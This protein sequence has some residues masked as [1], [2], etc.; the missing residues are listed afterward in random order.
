M[1]VAHRALRKVVVDD[2][3]DALEVDAARHDVRADQ[4]PHFALCKLADDIVAFG[5]APIGVNRVGVDPVEHELV[6]EFLGALDGL[7]KDE[8]GRRE[9]A[10]SDQGSEREEFV[11]FAV[12]K[13]ERLVDRRRCG[14]PISAQRDSVSH[15]RTRYP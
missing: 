4:A 9:L 1:D 12:D 15:L 3:F 14:L 7:D 6:R 2:E 11:V 13:E 8:D 10:R 5:G